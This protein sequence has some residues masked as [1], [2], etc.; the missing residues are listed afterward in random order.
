MTGRAAMT[1][2]TSTSTL[3]AGSRSTAR[4]FQLLILT[5]ALV[6]AFLFMQGCG[7]AAPSAA[8]AASTQPSGPSIAP[9]TANIQVWQTYQFSV[10]GPNAGASCTWATSD[11]SILSSLGGGEFQGM[12]TGTAKVTVTCDGASANAS[13]VI[14][15]QQQSGPIQ[16]TSGGTYSGNWTSNDP[17][18][19]A[20]TI[21]TD[22][23]VV[24]QDSVISGK[25]TLID[26]SG[27]KNGANVTIENVTATGLDPQTAGTQRGSFVNAT[28]FDSLIVRNCTMTGVSFG[29]KAYAASPS[30][31]S[32]VN[33]SATDLEDRASDGQ[34]GFE[35]SRPSKGHF[36]ILNG[37]AASAG[38]EIAWNKVVQTIGQSSTEDVINI[39][40]SQGS[41]GSPIEVHDNYL[42]GASSPVYTTHYTGTALITDGTGTNGAT[43]T[44]FVAFN[45]NQVVATAGTGLGIAAGHDISASGNR[46]VSC[47]MTANGNWYAWG[48]SAIVIWN[49]YQSASFYNNTI[50]TSAGGM[51]GPNT[52]GQP[53]VYDVWTNTAD[54]ADPG[55][56]V[57]GND[58]TN[59]CVASSGVNL[60]A[61]Q[62][63]RTYWTNKIAQA[64]EVIGD[65]HLNN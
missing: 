23:P 20:V 61:E 7:G 3:A 2:S 47:G 51:M 65:Q 15:A 45:D 11:A 30:T 37:I 63:E 25:G 62:A 18:T 52:N 1:P 27:V 29:V 4:L 40:N 17:A 36:V 19:P 43:P 34:G 5:L 31:L 26:I 46:I 50:T 56:S 14:A 41:A 38:A 21:R 28:Q 10:S 57:S 64:G 22:D 53:T 55:I 8:A 48:A 59:P 54:M 60:Q 13:V 6:P 49:Y 44:A 9:T 16:I 33:N 42:E 24:L 58:F 35:A 32:I 12:Q 39:Y